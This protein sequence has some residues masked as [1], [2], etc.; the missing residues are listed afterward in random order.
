M[1]EK[2]IDSVLIIDDK[3]NEI[4]ELQNILESKDIWVKYKN[5]KECSYK[6]RNR[7]IIFL[8]IYLSETATE[9]KGHISEIRKI[10]K[11]IIGQNFGT[12]G[13]VVWT[14]HLQHVDTIKE[15]IQLDKKQYDL[16]LFIC[17]LDKQKYLKD[18]YDSLLN[19]LEA[20]LKSNFAANFFINWSILVNQG[21]D[22]A[23]TDIFNLVP[24]YQ[25]QNNNLEFLLF[26]LAQNYTGIPIDKIDDYP[27][28]VDAIKAFND[29]L[30]SEVNAVSKNLSVFSSS[31]AIKYTDSENGIVQAETKKIKS[32]ELY[33]IFAEINSHLLIDQA[34]LSQDKVIPG[35]VYEVIKD[36]DRFKHPA[37]PV[38]AKPII[39]EMTPPCDFSNDKSKK[40]RVLAGYFCD[41]NGKKSPNENFYKELFPVKIKEFN[42]SQI[43]IFDFSILG[44]VDEDDLKDANKYKIL[45][46]AK[47]KLFADILQKMS[48]H[49]ARLGLSIIR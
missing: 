18:G 21:K 1:V 29:M 2:F 46:R 22:K 25:K 14:N 10:L 3:E 37:L 24:D 13:I 44:I 30:V 34:H 32:E 11:A 41:F 40:P 42:K 23:V 39:I 12:Y 4:K 8:D 49:T 27:L 5:P 33:N 7:K 6:F 15:K 17:G 26:K 19:D 45:F 38:N 9:L 31:N 28:S 48:S 47:D 43:V 16:P 35:N 20:E 36:D